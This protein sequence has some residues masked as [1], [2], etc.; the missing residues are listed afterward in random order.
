F[1]RHHAEAREADAELERAARAR[2]RAGA[3]IAPR[4]ALRLVE[5][6]PV[7]ALFAGDANAQAA[8]AGG[9]LDLERGAVELGGA[10]GRGVEAQVQRRRIEAEV[11]ALDHRRVGHR[12]AARHVVAA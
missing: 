6:P 12:R 3:E 10:R 8:R 5:P 9:D 7:V 11:D 2:G 4:V 1:A